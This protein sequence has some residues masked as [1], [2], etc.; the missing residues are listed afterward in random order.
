MWLGANAANSAELATVNTAW[1]SWS[2]IQDQLKTFAETPV[3]GPLGHQA[4]LTGHFFRTF[5]PI[6]QGP[7]IE[8]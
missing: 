7:G 3:V 4:G 2:L 8:V 1:R 6:L 5:H